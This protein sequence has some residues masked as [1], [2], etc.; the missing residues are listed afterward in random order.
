VGWLDPRNASA[1][2]VGV[3]LSPLLGLDFGPDRRPGKA[4]WQRAPLHGS[5]Q[6]WQFAPEQSDKFKKRIK[7]NA[8]VLLRDDFNGPQ[9]RLPALNYLLVKNQ[10]WGFLDGYARGLSECDW[11][12]S[13]I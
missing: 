12:R 13:E 10:A 2:L 6:K 9:A 5:I 7:S 1:E 3:E 8:A 4:S 11:N